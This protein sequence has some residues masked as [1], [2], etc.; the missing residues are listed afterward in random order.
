MDKR[1]GTAYFGNSASVEAVIHVKAVHLSYF[2]RK[3]IRRLLNALRGRQKVL[4][5][6]C[7]RSHWLSNKFSTPS[8]VQLVILVSQ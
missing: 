6:L 2:E 1:N 4:I 5:R 8:Q 7:S 3:T